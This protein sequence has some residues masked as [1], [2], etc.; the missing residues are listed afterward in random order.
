MEINKRTKPA[1]LS[2]YIFFISLIFYNNLINL[3]PSS[4][5]SR[6]YVWINLFTL[7]MLFVITNKYLKL[8]LNDLGYGMGYFIQ[9]MI[10][11]LILSAV[12]IFL[13]I[14]LLIILPHLPI[15]I[16]P[17]HIEANSFNE[18]LYRLL[19]RIPLGT[20]F[21]E[22]NLFRGICY[23]Y[24]IKNHSIKRAFLI[25]SLLFAVWHITPALKV[26][27]SNFQMAFNLLGIVVLFIGLLGAFFAGVFFALLRYYGKSIIG[28]ILAHA[29]IN[30]LALLIIRYIWK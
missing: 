7:S 25:T 20:A 11:G 9:S 6:I 15:K 26:V 5:H 22:E 27:S 3:L 30:D 23:G 10:I 28:C 14:I 24:L 21:F 8:S 13:F 2:V 18:L 29:L 16:N 12:V 4:L 17:P 1:T 19:F